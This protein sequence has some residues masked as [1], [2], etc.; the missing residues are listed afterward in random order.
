MAFKVS[1]EEMD[2]L[3]AQF[4]EKDREFASY[5]RQKQ[6]SIV[7]IA[8]GLYAGLGADALIKQLDERREKK[9]KLAFNVA[10]VVILIPLIVM[11]I[12]A[13]MDGVIKDSIGEFFVGLSIL[14]LGGYFF[15]RWWLV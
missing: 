11:C 10:G 9:K 7:H 6:E 3:V 12:S 13:M 2:T 4:S 5:S 8:L 1:K 15:Q 14:I